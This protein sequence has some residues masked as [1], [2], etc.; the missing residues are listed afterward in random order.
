MRENTFTHI[1]V[2]ASA[3]AKNCQTTQTE[4]GMATRIEAHKQPT[5]QSVEP[6]SNQNIALNEN[7]VT[8]S[9]IS[10]GGG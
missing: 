1:S 3:A 4:M 6:T 7:S 5:T 8:D 2:P 9:P 10:G